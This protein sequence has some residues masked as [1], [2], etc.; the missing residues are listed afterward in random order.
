M[1]TPFDLAMFGERERERELESSDRFS[2]RKVLWLLRLSISCRPLSPLQQRRMGPTM[3]TSRQARPLLITR[4]ALSSLKR[5]KQ[6]AQPLSVC[7]HGPLLSLGVLGLPTLHQ[8]CVC[9][10][11]CSVSFL[12]FDCRWLVARSPLQLT[13]DVRQKIE[14]SPPTPNQCLH[15]WQTSALMDHYVHTRTCAQRGVPTPP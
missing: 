10:C 9:V 15:C 8:V 14:R 12:L 7:V 3:S 2:S 6:R 5:Q 11:V 4:G 1:N 13:A